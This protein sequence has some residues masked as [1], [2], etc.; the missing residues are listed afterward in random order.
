MAL[1]EL[2]VCY[3]TKRQKDY[4]LADGEGLYLIIRHNGSN[5]WRMKYRFDGKEKLLS[6]GRYPDLSLA[7]ARLRRCRQ[8]SNNR[9]CPRGIGKRRLQRPGRG[10]LGHRRREPRR[11]SDE[12]SIARIQ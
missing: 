12:C 5:L 1:K 6:L 3:A 9:R 10:A 7:E 8:V 4:K 2:E 11:S